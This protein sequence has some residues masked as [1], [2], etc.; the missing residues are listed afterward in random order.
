MA[1]TAFWLRPGVP[2]RTRRPYHFH[3]PTSVHGHVRRPRAPA[4]LN[5]R[6]AF[7]ASGHNNHYRSTSYLLA[8]AL[9]HSER[10]RY[11]LVLIL[12]Q[13]FYYPHFALVTLP[14]SGLRLTHVDQSY[15]SPYCTISCSHI[16][17]G[18]VAY[19]VA[20]CRFLYDIRCTIPKSPY[21]S[22]LLAMSR[23]ALWRLTLYPQP[24]Q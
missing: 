13:H 20:D 8:F 19:N 16:C 17:Y 9:R 18:L 2:R 3:N 11:I 4:W 12:S 1:Q 7:S 21:C 15:G 23:S 10:S 22:E 6:K 5:G 24:Y 14:V